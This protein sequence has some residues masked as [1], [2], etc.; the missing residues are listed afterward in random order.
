MPAFNPSI[1][2][3]LMPGID[4]LSGDE[5]KC[6]GI[7]AQWASRSWML[8]MS[9]SVSG[10]PGFYCVV[11]VVGWALDIFPEYLK[12]TCADVAALYLAWASLTNAASG[13][14]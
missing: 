1:T 3:A 9:T 5:L 4:T 8:K 2:G 12:A 6:I 13:S 7:H 11:C 14:C 10:C